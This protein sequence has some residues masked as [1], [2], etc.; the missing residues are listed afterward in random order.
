M[1][2]LK[3]KLYNLKTYGFGIGMQKAHL[4]GAREDLDA[5][6]ANP[7]KAVEY[8][9]GYAQEMGNRLQLINRFSSRAF[10][11]ALPVGLAGFY[12]TNRLLFSREP[13][14][15]EPALE[16]PFL[17]AEGVVIGSLAKLQKLWHRGFTR[18][19]QV[20][21]DL[22]NEFEKMNADEARKKLSEL[23][24]KDITWSVLATS[25]SSRR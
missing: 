9:R 17:F 16:I 20:F 13:I 14:K 3:E 6:K 10:L 1:V 21:S 5:L 18:G 2:T 4:K 24:P 22:A 25:D 23:R 8:F 15:F 7:D 19:N 12:L 11:Y